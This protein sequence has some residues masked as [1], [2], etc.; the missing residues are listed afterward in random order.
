MGDD[1]AGCRC[2]VEVRVCRVEPG[3]DR[4]DPDV[5]P[6]SSRPSPGPLGFDAGRARVEVSL[7]VL[8]V[9]DLGGGQRGFG[10]DDLDRRDFTYAPDAQVDWGAVGAQFAGLPVWGSGANAPETQMMSSAATAISTSRPIVSVS[11][12]RIL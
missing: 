11:P 4:N 8:L 7:T 6:G 12:G 5:L 10:L 3:V 2:P 1:D 9:G